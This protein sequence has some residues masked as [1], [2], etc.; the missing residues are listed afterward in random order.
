MI[1]KCNTILTDSQVEGIEGENHLRPVWLMMDKIE[2]V[3]DQSGIT[4]AL[5]TVIT[6]QSGDAFPVTATVQELEKVMNQWN[7][8]RT[9]EMIDLQ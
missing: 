7:T 9:Y 2:S 8:R 3:S 5:P 6:M 1:L 4:D